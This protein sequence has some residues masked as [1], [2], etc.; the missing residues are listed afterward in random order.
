MIIDTSV[1]VALFLQEPDAPALV[2]L[3]ADVPSRRLS[4]ASH[5]ELAA[6]IDGRRDP[7]LTGALDA[8]LHN[9]RIEIAEFTVN[10]AR[11]A[12]QAC[13]AVRARRRPPR[14]A[15]APGSRRPR[16]FWGDRTSGARPFYGTALSS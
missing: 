11:I 9:M 5:V 12:R 1:L 4:A 3:M 7:V 6:V 2:R 13:R 15:A 14:P 16:P 10:Q 8:K